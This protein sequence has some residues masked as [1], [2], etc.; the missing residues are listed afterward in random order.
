MQM[1]HERAYQEWQQLMARIGQLHAKYPGEELHKIE[2]KP[3]DVIY[4]LETPLGYRQ[5]HSDA[6]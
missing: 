5:K 2:Y 6:A 3:R 4:L 1:N